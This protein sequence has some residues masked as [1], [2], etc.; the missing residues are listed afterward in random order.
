MVFWA[1]AL[2]LTVTFGA[3]IWGRTGEVHARAVPAEIAPKHTKNKILCVLESLD[4]KSENLAK[5][6]KTDQQK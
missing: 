6:L 5:K 1:V 3:V 4:A 2:A